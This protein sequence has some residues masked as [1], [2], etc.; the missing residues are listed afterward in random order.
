[1]P[2][3]LRP[4]VPRDAERITA[5]LTEGF[6]SSRSFAPP[7]WVPPDPHAELERL[8]AFLGTEEVWCLVAEDGGETAGHVAI[9]PARIHPHPSD[10]DAMGHFWQLFV[11]EPWWGSGL[12]TA[13]HAEAVREAGARGFTS[14]RLFTP[15]PTRVPG[16][17]TSA[18]AGRRPAPRSTA[19]ASASRSGSTGAR[20]ASACDRSGP[21]AGA[22]RA[23]RAGG[24]PAA[25]P[26]GA[27]ASRR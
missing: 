23:R 6:E 5:V 25:P 21:A 14:M 17:S 18:R 10:D 13:L 19:S 24:P 22:S 9:M 20:S 2:W 8:R 26:P 15:P 4:A 11:R 16:A 1:M 3:S 12:A 7:D 27:A